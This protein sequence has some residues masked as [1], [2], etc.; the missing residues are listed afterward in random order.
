MEL[1]PRST[2]Q[3]VSQ[4][5]VG[6]SCPLADIVQVAIHYTAA[7]RVDPN[8]ASY[9]RAIQ[10]DYTV[11]RGY[12]IGY[13]FAVDQLGRTWE[14]RG[15]DIKCAANKGRNHDTLAIICLVDGDNPATDRMVNTVR[16]VVT[17]IR[18]HAPNARR[19]VGH[20]QIGAT[21][22]PGT[23]LFSQVISGMFE[24]TAQPPTPTPEP[25]PEEDDVKYL[26][27]RVPS[28]PTRAE[29]LVAH[30]GAGIHIIGFSTPADRD[31][32]TAAMGAVKVDVSAQQYDAY[33]TSA[34]GR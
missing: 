28:D 34:A 10:R 32:I 9:L 31:R 16:E 3:L 6:P 7:A 21:S 14:L 17:L 27:I 33:L 11:N 24:P 29:A 5:V 25:P 12:S 26:A 23:G 30:D 8:T 2:W 19:I 1:H 18:R 4:P 22:C 20:R 15:L 13:N